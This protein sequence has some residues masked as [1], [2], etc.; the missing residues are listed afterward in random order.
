M[1]GKV[2]S[3]IV[4][5]LTCLV[6]AGG[7]ARNYSRSGLM[8]QPGGAIEASIDGETP[9]LEV[10]NAGE[11]SVD[12]VILRGDAE[13]ERTPVGPGEL[14]AR[15]VEG[16]LGVRVENTSSRDS[17][18][19]IEGRNGWGFRV[20]GANPPAGAKADQAR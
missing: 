4:T 5:V 20:S 19:T 6:I 14:V 3:L 10:H 7:C 17:L 12:V 13:I 8:L 15:S 2:A 1:T 18:V 9:T 16:G 11:G